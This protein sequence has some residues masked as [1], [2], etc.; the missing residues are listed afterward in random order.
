[1]GYACLVEHWGGVALLGCPW[2]VMGLGRNDTGA[3]IGE[4][5][6]V[7]TPSL[8]VSFRAIIR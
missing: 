1:V 7:C 6:V 2:N 5:V 8:T 4:R 3:R